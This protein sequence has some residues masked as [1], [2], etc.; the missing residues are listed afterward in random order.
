MTCIETGAYISVE[1][2]GYTIPADLYQVGDT[3]I[4][5]M[6]NENCQSFDS[7]PLKSVTHTVFLSMGSF[8]RPDIGI[9]VVP[10]DHVISA[11]QKEQ[12]Q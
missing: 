10:D 9:L 2:Y 7:D 4:A 11:A 5:R 12:A 6:N 3:I 1:P 8:Y